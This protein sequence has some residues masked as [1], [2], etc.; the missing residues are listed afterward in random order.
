MQPHGLASVRRRPLELNAHT[1]LTVN[2]YVRRDQVNY[3]PSR[4]LFADTPATA[5]QLRFLTNYGMK[6]D[7]SFTSGR[8]NAKF[9]TQLQQTR[10]LENFQFAITDANYNAVC[11]DSAGGPL[12]LPGV[13]D[14]D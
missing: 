14:P 3:S 13:S 5:S 7:V 12:L 4:N 1:L 2:P 10:L 11:L 9:G 8:H 6:V